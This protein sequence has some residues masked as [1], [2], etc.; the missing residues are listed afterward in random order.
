MCMRIQRGGGGVL[1]LDGRDLLPWYDLLL[2]PSPAEISF[3]LGWNCVGSL[4]VML[5]LRIGNGYTINPPV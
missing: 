4:Q 5:I 2:F 1:F 3:S